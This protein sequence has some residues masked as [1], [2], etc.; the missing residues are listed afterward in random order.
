MSVDTTWQGVLQGIDACMRAQLGLADILRHCEDTGG[1][2]PEDPV[3]VDPDD[4]RTLVQAG[5]LSDREV[6]RGGA[7]LITARGRAALRWGL[8]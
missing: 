5:L 2:L 4:L 6:T 7:Y 3:L 1:L 8:V